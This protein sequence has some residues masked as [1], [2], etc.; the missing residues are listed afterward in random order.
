MSTKWGNSREK[1]S[2]KLHSMMHKSQV[3]H[4]GEKQ[5]K[6]RLI[7]IFKMEIISS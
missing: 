1:K 6:L 5:N 3:N 2:S 7:K 4:T